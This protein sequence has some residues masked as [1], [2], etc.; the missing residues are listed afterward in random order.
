MLEWSPL[1]GPG[2]ADGVVPLRVAEED[3]SGTVE[4]SEV[5]NWSAPNVRSGPS[6]P[7]ASAVTPFWTGL[8]W[9]GTAAPA[10]AASVG[11]RGG[12]RW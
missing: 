5:S 11:E 3:A 10:S 6:E 2:N 12:V 7:C 8:S 1:A 9:L 4:R